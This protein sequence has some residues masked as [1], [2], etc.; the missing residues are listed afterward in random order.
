MAQRIAAAL[1]ISVQAV[2]LAYMGQMVVFPI[3]T[4]IVAFAAALGPFR[5]NLSRRRVVYLLG[6]LGFAF[7]IGYLIA[8]PAIPLRSVSIGSRETYAF[9]QFLIA[10]QLLQLFLRRPDGRLPAWLTAAAA[11][12]M[13]CAANV[14]PLARERTVFLWL[15]LGFLATA[16]FYIAASSRPSKAV[17]GENRA[18]R[19]MLIVGTT[20][21]ALVLA[22]TSATLLYR[23]ERQLDN[24]FV[25]LAGRAGSS[26]SVGFSGKARLSSVTEFRKEGANNIAL[27]IAAEDPPIY[28]R[29]A[30]FDTYVN[31]RWQSTASTQLMSISDVPPAGLTGAGGFRRWFT[32]RQTEADTWRGYEIWNDPGLS[33]TLFSPLGAAVAQASFET[34][35]VDEHGIVQVLG[36]V[37]DT[38]YSVYV[39]ANET[40]LQPSELYSQSLIGVPDWLEPA[41]ADLAASICGTAESPAAKIRAVEDYFHDNY[42]YRVGIEVP[43]GRDPLTYFLLER[44][45]AHCEYFAAG[46]TMLLRQCGVPCRY[47]TGFVVTEREPFSQEWIARNKDAHAWAEAWD[48]DRGW[49][50]VEAT[51]Y[52]GVPVAF[53]AST[54][55]H[56]WEY[57]RDHVRMLWSKVRRGDLQA[58]A[59]LLLQ[60]VWTP[61]T[62]FLAAG[63]AAVWLLRRSV[64]H[65]RSK[66]QRVRDPRFKGLSRLLDRMDHRLQKEGLIRRSGETLHQFAG[67]VADAEAGDGSM[68]AAADWYRD[69]AELR[70]GG[71]FDDASVERL[72][73]L[74]IVRRRRQPA[75]SISTT[76]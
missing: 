6:A 33:D 25:R 3:A 69:Y 36:F 13:V 17:Q 74:P 57:V 26:G 46:A 39:P 60:L 53:E 18:S 16:A 42:D 48:D 27:R 32:L 11:G 44:P 28:M 2:V 65:R 12:C 35:T 43:A 9:G 24:L 14:A 7:G 68:T 41:V 19:T 49:V 8:P 4:A 76:P 5:F 34:A 59:R 56:L 72:A 31:S 55:R 67:R 40:G 20:A 66:E 47:V 64:R 54:Q 45:P 70:Y 30:A 15:T 38:S 52:S 1:L 37:P 58:A 63:A 29:G 50:V 75:A 61:L 73:A 23:Y 22:W 62:L 71:Q 10:A 21:A 51:P